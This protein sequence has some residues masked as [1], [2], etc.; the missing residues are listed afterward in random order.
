MKA[1]VPEVTVVIPTRDR[2]RFLRR[3]LDAAL[4]QEDVHAEV[5]VVDD[6]STD[7]TPR[8]LEEL[9]DPRVRAIRVDDGR[10]VGAARNAGIAAACGEWI[11]FLDDD[12]IWSPRKLRTQLDA[13]R[14]A[15]GGFAYTGA[16][17]LDGSLAAVHVSPAPPPEGLLELTRAFNPIPAGSSNVLVH[18]D[19]LRRVGLFDE[20]LHQLADWELWIRLAGVGPAVA[21]DEPL[22]G[23]VQH[24]GQML[25]ADT[26]DVFGELRYLDRKHGGPPSSPEGGGNRRLFWRWAARGDLEAGRNARAARLALRGEWLHHGRGNSFAGALVLA[27]RVLRRIGRTRHRPGSA[28][29]RAPAWVED[30][31]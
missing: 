25:L 2:W 3:A 28:P 26:T 6:G 20:R 5:V 22:V 18:A 30:Y 10:G 14:A 1:D 7:E 12:D 11:A 24:A 27:W 4:R 23:Y 29:L 17:L 9:G 21:C 16:V 15:G 8:R 19:L 13:L 31:R